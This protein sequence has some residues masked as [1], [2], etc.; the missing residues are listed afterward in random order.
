VFK[1][2]NTGHETVLYNFCSEGGANCTDGG[3]PTGGL[4]QGASTLYGTASQGG[5][6]VG[7]TVFK[8]AIASGVGDTATVTLT[9]SPNPTYVDQSV[10]S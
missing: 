3:F 4:I 10:Q 9:S 6:A 7:G 8:L 2:D 5:A 1:L